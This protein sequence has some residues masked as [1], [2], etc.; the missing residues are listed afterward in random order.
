MS[1]QLDI[2]LRSKQCLASLESL[3]WGIV[4]NRSRM[5]SRGRATVSVSEAVEL[6]WLVILDIIALSF[7]SIE[8]VLL[9]L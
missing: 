2:L 1:V 6:T 4:S 8:R 5:T 3:L 7:F 9:D